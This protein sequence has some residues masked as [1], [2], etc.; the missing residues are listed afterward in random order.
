MN[1]QIGNEAA[2]FHFWDY[3]FQIFSTVWGM[4]WAIYLVLCTITRLRCLLRP[5]Q[6]S[7]LGSQHGPFIYIPLHSPAA[8]HSGGMAWAIFLVH[9]SIIGLIQSIF[10]PQ[11]PSTLQNASPASS[12]TCKI[13]A[14]FILHM[15]QNRFLLRMFHFDLPLFSLSEH[16]VAQYWVYLLYYILV[17]PEY[18]I[19]IIRETSHFIIYRCCSTTICQ[20]T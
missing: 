3:M 4:A 19:I 18:T 7:L 6:L 5:L 14:T 16:T 20:S 10:P 2:Q 9:Y 12:H 1:A 17:T 8:L 15:I 13:L 11:Q